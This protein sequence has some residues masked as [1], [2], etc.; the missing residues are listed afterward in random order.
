MKI[1]LV[2]LILPD[3][4]IWINLLSRRPKFH[5]KEQHLV[6]F[7]TCGPVIQEVL[8]GLR[9]HE[10][11]GPFQNSFLALPQIGIPTALDL[12]LHAADIYRMGKTKGFSIRSSI[13]C[14]IAA[15]AIANN[16]PVWHD[17][18]DFSIIARYTP[19]QE[20]TR[21]ED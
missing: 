21:L 16:I 19:L 8:Q 9:S 11:A 17:D 14:L 20:F 5:P 12:F 2:S 15:I 6:R 7:V 1:G 10:L 3:T 13:D 4:S 18:R